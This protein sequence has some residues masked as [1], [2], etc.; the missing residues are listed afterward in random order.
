MLKL[1][2]RQGTVV[3]GAVSAVAHGSSIS[4]IQVWGI[5]CNHYE[6]YTLIT[7]LKLP[8]ESRIKGI[9]LLGAR[10]TISL[11]KIVKTRSMI[12]SDQLFNILCLRNTVKAVASGTKILLSR[13]KVCCCCCC[14]C[15]HARAAFIIVCIVDISTRPFLSYALI[16]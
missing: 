7:C 15:Q 2:R 6:I 11:H 12:S 10:I 5:K 13:F 9:K 8:Q 1:S 3:D 16:Q 4:E 14:C